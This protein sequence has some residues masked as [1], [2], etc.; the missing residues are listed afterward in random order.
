MRKGMTPQERR[1]WHCYLRRHPMHFRRQKVIYHYIADFFCHAAQLVI[2][3]DGS[4]HSQP[5]AAEYDRVRTQALNQLNLTVLRFRNDEI[6]RDF[7]R[8]CQTIERAI[9]GRASD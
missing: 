7:P 3:V 9:K 8:V 2:E 6:D 4:Q 1:L 5:D